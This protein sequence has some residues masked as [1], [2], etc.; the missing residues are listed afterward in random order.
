M[1]IEINICMGSAC[2]ARGNDKNIE[3]I[4][5]Y[6]TENNLDAKVDITA[7]LCNGCCADGPNIFVNGELHADMTLEK[8]KNLLL[9]LSKNE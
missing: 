5:K 9:E 6:I 8:V 2:Y 4:E 1:T 3:Y 7:S